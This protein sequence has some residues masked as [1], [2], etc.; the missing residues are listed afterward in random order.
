M[1]RQTDPT[2]L[3]R[4]PSLS[5][6][7]DGSP[8]CGLCSVRGLQGGEQLQPHK[9]GSIYKPLLLLN[10]IHSLIICYCSQ[11]LQPQE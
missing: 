2:L 9:L 10:N 7:V 11:T 8:G 5:L 4:S 3:S 6:Q 1:V